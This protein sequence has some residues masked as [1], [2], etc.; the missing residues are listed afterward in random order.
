MFNRDL[1]HVS[2]GPNNWNAL[3][4]FEAKLAHDHRIIMC[5]RR[6]GGPY[7]FPCMSQFKVTFWVI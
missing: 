1:V 7:I 6:V 5:A 2:E 3:S 4:G